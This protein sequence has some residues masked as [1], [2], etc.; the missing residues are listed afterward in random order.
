MDRMAGAKCPGDGGDLANAE[1]FHRFRFVTNN[2]RPHTTSV[3]CKKHFPILS[4]LQIA[5]EIFADVK[6]GFQIPK[7]SKLSWRKFRWH[8]K[9]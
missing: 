5:L 2:G 7:K 3:D 9:S 8:T 1:N 4:A 6:L